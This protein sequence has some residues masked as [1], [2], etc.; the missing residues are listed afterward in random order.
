M[1]CSVGNAQLRSLYLEMDDMTWGCWQG[2]LK[3]RD[4]KKGCSVCLSG[5]SEE[6]TSGLTTLWC[7]CGGGGGASLAFWVGKPHGDFTGSPVLLTEMV[8]AIPGWGVG[9]K[10][11]GPLRIESF[12]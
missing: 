12:K 1:L 8:P 5:G 11:Q 6:A 4:R 7:V 3:G 10:A 2:S 9:L